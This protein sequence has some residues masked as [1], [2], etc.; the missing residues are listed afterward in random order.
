MASINFGELIQQLADAPIRTEEDLSIWGGNFEAERLDD[1]LERWKLDQREMPWRIWEQV[2]KIVFQWETQ[3][4]DSEL[5]E[6]GQLFGPGGDLSLRRNGSRLLWHFIGPAGVE[7]PAGFEAR[8]YWEDEKR[9][10]LREHEESVLLWGEWRSTPGRWLEDRV[11]QADLQYPK[12]L[13]E[14]R[15]WLDYWRYEEAGQTAFVWYRRLRGLEA[16]NG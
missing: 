12:V 2:S 14:E 7:P 11:G 16:N 1:F 8:S 5:L 13:G 9:R 4:G 6:R 3:P 10:P 15:V